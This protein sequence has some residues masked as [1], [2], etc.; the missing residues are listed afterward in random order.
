M[1]LPRPGLASG[2]FTPSLRRT[3]L[4]VGAGANFLAS[5]KKTNKRGG[6]TVAQS[7][8]AADANGDRVVDAGTFMAKITSGDDTGKYG[9]YSSTATD[10][11]QTP[12][13]D[14]SGY[15]PES[16]N[17]RDGDVITGL[18]IQGSVLAARVK[19]AMTTAG[20][21]AG[22]RSAVAGRILFQ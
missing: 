20:S 7:T 16:V 13:R 14:D 1:T 3:T 17:C 19:P 9:P 21:Y 12:S 4:N 11:R 15:L 6:I 2:G 22:I 8:V 5:E 10:G 18:I